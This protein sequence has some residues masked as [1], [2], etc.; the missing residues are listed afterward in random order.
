MTARECVL[1]FLA[2]AITP[3]WAYGS[4]DLDG[5]LNEHMRRLNQ[6]PEE[7]R[8]RLEAR[9]LRAMIAAR[10]VFDGDAFRKRYKPADQ[11]KPINKALF[12]CWSVGLDALSNDELELLVQRRAALRERFVRLMNDVAF[13]AAISQGTG[14]TKKVQRRFGE[15]GRII[16]ETLA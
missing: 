5:F 13:D 9:F 4:P 1:R 16:R 6:M 3:Y 7:E 12:E 11:R 10:R 14:D 8:N 15:V 2:F